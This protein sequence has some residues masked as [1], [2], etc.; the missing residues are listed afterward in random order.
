VQAFALRAEKDQEFDRALVG[1]VGVELGDFTWE[2]DDVQFAEAQP[3]LAVEHIHPFLA[4][5]DL[6]LVLAFAGR[7]GPRGR[8]T[9][10]TAWLGG[11]VASSRRSEPRG[12]G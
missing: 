9:P 3:Q 11:Y 5:M 2:R 7:T 8:R 1:A 4:L 6:Q 12:P 10:D